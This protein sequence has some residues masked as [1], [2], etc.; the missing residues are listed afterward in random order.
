MAKLRQE[1]RFRVAD[2]P[3]LGGKGHER[4]E[5]REREGIAKQTERCIDSLK[6]P[7]TFLFPFFS[8]FLP[9]CP[10]V[11]H[12]FL[13][14]FGCTNLQ[15]AAGWHGGSQRCQV[16]VSALLPSLSLPEPLHNK[17]GNEQ[18]NRGHTH[19]HTHTGA[20]DCCPCSGENANA[21]MA[22]VVLK[23][24][25]PG[26]QAPST[27]QSQG[28]QQR[29]KQTAYSAY[30]G[31]SPSLSHFALFQSLSPTEN[32]IHIVALLPY[33]KFNVPSMNIFEQLL[34]ISARQLASICACLLDKNILLYLC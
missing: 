24:N 6:P 30:P 16:D 8:V 21:R 33:L 18:A 22:V 20:L 13:R 14:L 26:R 12:T 15:R 4:V 17:T 3:R 2:R 27:R 1:Q 5:G 10:S 31:L 19:T 28:G 34:Q 7:F 11:S 29:D 32:Y 23:G 9:I 25:D